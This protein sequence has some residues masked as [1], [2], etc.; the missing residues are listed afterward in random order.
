MP[1]LP[2][3]RLPNPS[4]AE[5]PG[6]GRN[7][8]NLRKPTKGRQRDRF[9]PIFDRL[10]AVLSRTRGPIELRDDPT[11]LAPERV[12]VFEIG[13]TVANFLNALGKIDGLEFMA[14]MDTD[15]AADENFAV[16]YGDA[17]R[18]G[19]DRLDKAVPG[20]LYL[21]MPDLQAL[22]ELLALWERW[23]NNEPLGRGYAP[24]GNLFSQLHDLRP[25]G[26]QDRIPPETIDFWREEI[27]RDP[28]RSVRTEIELW[29]HLNEARRRESAGAI[30]AALTEV[31]GRVVHE[32][33]IENIAYHG[34][35]VDIPSGYVQSLIELQAVKLALA[36][37][38]MFLR[39]QSVLS[40]PQEIE[41]ATDGSVNA[42]GTAA[43]LSSGEPIAALLDGM[44]VQAHS[45]LA[46][47]IIIDDPD[48]LES[49]ALVSQRM[50]GTGMA[51]LILH[52]DRNEPGETLS[53]PLY[54]RPLML[55]NEQGIEQTDNDRLLIDTIHRAVLHIKGTEAEDGAAPSVFLINLSMGDV[56]RPFSGV[57]SPLAR[58]LDYMA[59]KYG[60]LFLVSGGNVIGPLEIADFP[61]WTAFE[62]AS[63]EQRERA[64]IK[65]L[66]N[67]KHE[68]TILS[69]AEALN[70]LTIGAR[71][72][73]S[74][75]DRQGTF[76]TIDPLQDDTLP[77][78]TS[79]L[80]LGYR[81]MIKPE[82]YL[83]GGR[84]HVRMQASGVTLKVIHSQPRRIYGLS[85]AAPDA[86]G[87][88][89]LDQVAL[90]AGTSPATA[91]A[92]RAAA[93]IFEALMDVEG[94]SLLAD[95][96]PQY[97]AVVVKTLLLH[98]S[99]WSDNGDMLK[100]ICGPADHRRHVERADNSAR[101]VGY[102]IPDITRALECSANRA[103][104]V[105]YGALQVDAAHSYRIPLPASLERVTD[106][107][108]LSVT[109]AWTSPIKA[110]HQS[111]RGVK[112]EAAPDTPFEVFGVE[113]GKSQPADPTCKRGS[114]FHE[115]F[116]GDA[117]VAFIDDGH[118]ALRVW[119]KE[120]AGVADGTMIRYGVAV[121]IE[122]STP[123]PIYEEVQQRLRVR[124]RP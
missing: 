41:A 115:H 28:G 76:N 4:R 109:L 10:R 94:G 57:M 58:L 89:R 27:A 116:E 44:P 11:A 61:N 124:P 91:L 25:W 107:R 39:P 59:D 48:N 13:G 26:P 104:M 42:V 117:A 18:R 87:Q 9:G 23:K 97:Y 1:E 40:D 12:I 53:R 105:G 75:T 98:S 15:F 30:R 102:G 113:R 5:V 80:G 60:I 22:R 55:I 47:H 120:D 62:R 36:D 95:I 82:L 70:V 35:L 100:D 17:K 118:L 90:T 64:V 33:S 16:Q 14:E 54:I 110:G 122:A 88:G 66:N 71:H 74:V 111:Y 52:G 56:R 29:Y 65:S 108:S 112:M 31:G 84:E 8:S 20:R 103:T 67:A 68:R 86:R 6:G 34:M 78:I 24:I 3:L 37:E 99:H 50:H 72:H 45:L 101:F 119:C 121:T 106:P 49:R 2:L 85:T 32:S 38:V 21:A 83:S 43:D 114:A 123:L 19:Q 77:N 73:D 93:Q 46:N 63:P 69:P 96:G 7:I 79:G 51:S 92:T 81:R